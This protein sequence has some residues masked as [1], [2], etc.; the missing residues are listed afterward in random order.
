MER[1][2]RLLDSRFKRRLMGNLRIQHNQ[3]FLRCW[4]KGQ[5]L[6]L[7]TIWHCRCSFRAMLHRTAYLSTLESV[8]LRSPGCLSSERPT[9]T[10]FTW[11]EATVVALGFLKV[12]QPSSGIT[13]SFNWWDFHGIHCY[14]P[15]CFLFADLLYGIDVSSTNELTPLYISLTFIFWVVK[16]KSIYTDFMYVLDGGISSKTD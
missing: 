8:T 4:K 16:D 5:F 15:Y 12:L 3:V 2:E 13:L 14:F 9:W 11:G 7:K 1:G 6:P 10:D